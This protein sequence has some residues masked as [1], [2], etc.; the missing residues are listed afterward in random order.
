M[1]I[2][3]FAADIYPVVHAHMEAAKALESSLKKRHT[4]P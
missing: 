1:R 4:T 2:N 3:Q